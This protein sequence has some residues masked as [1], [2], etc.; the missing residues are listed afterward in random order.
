MMPHNKVT[1][2]GL[3]YDY[4]SIMHYS[5]TAFAKNKTQPSIIPIVSNTY[6]ILFILKY[7]Y[8]CLWIT[9]TGANN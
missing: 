5:M 6:T 1:T 3:P 8:T 9:P 4:D 2:Y 7:N